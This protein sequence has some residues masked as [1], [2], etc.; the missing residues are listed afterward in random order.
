MNEP[1]VPNSG[2][3]IL[4]R[5]LDC[6]GHDACHLEPVGIG[7]QVAGATAFRQGGVP[8]LV[9]YRVAYDAD[10]RTE[11]GS[12]HGWLGDKTIE[13]RAVW[14]TGGLWKLN[15]ETVKGLDDCVDLDLGLTPATNL[16]QI[17]RIALPV[18][19]AADVPVAW[20]DPL[21]GAFERLVQRYER[22]S[23]TTYW[24]EAPRFEYAAELVVRPDGFVR[25]Y[26]RLWEAEE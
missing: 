15:G 7:F 24:Y 23:E 1:E 26:P 19:R 10:W 9:E 3:T 5:R 4:W 22:R 14:G 21:T 2:E 8:A 12:V 20:L 16:S 17:R 25:S 11:Q 6:P 18:G 13:W